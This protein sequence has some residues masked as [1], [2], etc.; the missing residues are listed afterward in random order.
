MQKTD[1]ALFNVKIWYL[2][3]WVCVITLGSF[4]FGYGTV[5]FNSLTVM[6]YKQY[7]YHNVNYID[8]R[9]TFN[10]IVTTMVILG[11]FVGSFSISPL[12]SFG[13]RNCMLF[14]DLIIIIGAAINLIFNFWALLMGRLLVGWG[15]GAFTV[16]APIMINEISPTSLSGMLGS[17]VQIQFT[18]GFLIAYAFGLHVPYQ[19]KSDGT[20]N[21][22]IYT[23]EIWKLI[24]V[25][26]GIV[27]LLQILLLLTIYKDDTPTYYRQ[28]EDNEK[29]SS[30]L[31]KIY[32]EYETENKLYESEE[33][34]GSDLEDTS[35]IGIFE[36][37]YLY[38]LFI[39][40]MIYVITKTTGVNAIFFYSNEIFTLKH[41]GH[42]AEKEARIGTL[43]IGVTMFLT[44]FL[45][46]ILLMKLGRR[47]I[48]I[49]GHTGMLI[50]L[51]ALGISAIYELNFC[52]KIFTVC[53]LFF[54]NPS[55]GT[56]C[57]I[58][59]AEILKE[60]AVSLGTSLTW[61]LTI[62]FSL[63]TNQAFKLLT[64]EGVYFSFA[65]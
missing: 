25:F 11:A 5:Y 47:T 62:L 22:E 61:A 18:F 39:G 55:I 45:S 52:I 54:F 30:T 19:T 23:S 10:S 14:V 33:R 58:I 8:N 59:G 2:V 4:I 1:T 31:S 36:K 56:L 43:M 37:R 42:Q 35:S 64:A 46:P 51:T 16:I 15:C 38:T 7:K 65:A 60:K 34:S 48:L 13:M 63:F 28:K 57:W 21:L 27:A 24:F 20:E 44:S 53:S 49:I 6:I 40:M 32:V 26:P 50:F 9:D 41:T 29:F 17:I 12:L 3:S